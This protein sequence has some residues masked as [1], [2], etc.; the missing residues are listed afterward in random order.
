MKGKAFIDSSLVFYTAGSIGYRWAVKVMRIVA[1]NEGRVSA[2]VLLFQEILDFFWQ[3]HDPDRAETLFAATRGL[4]SDV[5]PVTAEDFDRSAELHASYPDATPRSLLRIAT[6][7]N[8]GSKELCATYSA[9]LEGI[10]EI[11]RVNLMEEIKT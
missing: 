3:R 6:M 11:T 5:V 10:K 7:L 4:L 9:E 1:E 8:N 2:D